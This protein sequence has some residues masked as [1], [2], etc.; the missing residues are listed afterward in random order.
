MPLG[1]A[2]HGKNRVTEKL[3]DGALVIE[4][5]AG[6]LLKVAIE[7]RHDL[8]RWQLLR[9]HIAVARLVRRRPALQDSLTSSDPNR[10]VV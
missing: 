3:I 6:H 9:R 1:R 8:G 4:N 5:D 10:M 7:Q 2:E